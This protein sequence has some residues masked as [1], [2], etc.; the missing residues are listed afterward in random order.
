MQVLSTENHHLQNH[1][2]T[3]RQ[4]L[5]D[6]ESTIQK[7]ESKMSQQEAKYAQQLAS[8]TATQSA[9]KKGSVH[10]LTDD[11]LY[12]ESLLYTK[13]NSTEIN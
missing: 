8:Q 3:T 7:L 13:R 10:F 4:Q 5:A 6:A 2:A 9:S 1:L 11:S 12:V